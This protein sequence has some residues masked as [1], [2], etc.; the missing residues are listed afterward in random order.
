VLSTD[1]KSSRVSE[2]RPKAAPFVALEEIS[3]VY[4]LIDRLLPDWA[5][6]VKN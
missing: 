5:R 2:L 1:V 4:E 6:S 3:A